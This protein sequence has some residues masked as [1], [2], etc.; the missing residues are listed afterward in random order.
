M[1]EKKIEPL[2]TVLVDFDGTLNVHSWPRA[3]PRPSPGAVYFMKELVRRGYTVLIFSSRAWRG[4]IEKAGQEFYDAQYDQMVKWLE[5]YKIPH[6][7]ITAE[8]VP[9]LLIVDDRA[10]NPKFHGWLGI[11]KMLDEGDDYGKIAVGEP[12]EIEEE[13]DAKG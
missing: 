8:K 10:A 12:Y 4:W 11:L 3:I 2:R 1:T 13:R 9:A 6:H 5:R 7:G